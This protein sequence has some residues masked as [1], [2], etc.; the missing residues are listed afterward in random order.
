MYM[1][2]LKLGF[3]P[4]DARGVL[5]LDAA[6]K[7]VYTYS[8]YEW[9]HILDLRYFETTGKAHPNAKLIAKEIYNELSIRYNY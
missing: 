6:T 7:V 8:A 5:P 2:C 4:Q 3:L 9:K 1:L